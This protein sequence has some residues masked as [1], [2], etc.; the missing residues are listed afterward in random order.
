MPASTS[1]TTVLAE[2][3]STNARVLRIFTGH[4]E[5]ITPTIMPVSHNAV[6]GNMTPQIVGSTGTQI[7]LGPD[8]ISMLCGL[9]LEAIRAVGGIYNFMGW[10]KPMLSHSGGYSTI[11]NTFKI[12]SDDNELI[13]SASETGRQFRL[14][15]ESYIETQRMI[16][17]DIVIALD[18][19]IPDNNNWRLTSKALER[20]HRWL[21]ISRAFHT[22][23]PRST[24]GQPQM[25]FGTI[26]GGRFRDLRE[27][28]AEFVSR[29]EVDGVA[30]RRG[31]TDCS[32][33][34]TLDMLDWVMP[35]IP[36]DKPRYIIGAANNPS[37]LLSLIRGGIDLFDFIA[38][39]K[40]SESGSVYCGTLVQQD[41]WLRFQS[42]YNDEINLRDKIFGEDDRPICDWCPCLACKNYSRAYLHY[43]LNEDARD[44]LS[45]ANIHNI[46]MM[47]SVCSAARQLITE[48]KAERV[49]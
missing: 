26:E 16:G 22:R 49:L 27:Q 29:Q 33:P 34:E 41:G 2:F 48:T 5:I 23:N 28:S 18:H 17:A 20:A 4:G 32:I 3:Q 36:K 46:H 21:A 30:I 8:A 10:T 31:A 6:V 47:Q 40:I 11:S 14:S 13:F 1:E 42:P 43:L 25:L 15:P 39:T 9:G 7:I 45:L 24:Y 37:D 38:P 12:S 35:I 44:Y 19:F